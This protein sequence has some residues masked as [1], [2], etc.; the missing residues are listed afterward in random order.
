M[1]EILEM[2]EAEVHGMLKRVS[3]GHFACSLDDQPYIVPIHF[4]YQEPFIY[5]YTTRGLKTEI[6]SANPKVCLQAEEVKDTEEWKSIVVN[7]KAVSITDPAEREEAFELLLGSNP[8]LM[9][10]LG[11]KWENDWI[12]ENHEV[13]YRITPDS[14]SGRSS[15]KVRM[16]TAAARPAGARHDI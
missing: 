16:Q 13:I 11:I 12:R 1:I 2:T 3:V 6:I 5:I 15:K 10:A 7:G 14:V 4:V 9:P 8:T